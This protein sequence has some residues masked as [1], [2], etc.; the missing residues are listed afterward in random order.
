MYVTALTE[1]IQQ[2]T[3]MIHCKNIF[4]VESTCTY[5]FKAQ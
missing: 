2:L 4:I 3:E 1:S 5:G